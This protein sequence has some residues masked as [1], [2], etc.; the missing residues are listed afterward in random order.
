MKKIIIILLVLQGCLPY[1]DYKHLTLAKK[2]SGI[3]K[4]NLKINGIYY[5]TSTEPTNSNYGHIHMFILYQDGTYLRMNP[6]E[7][8]HYSYNKNTVILSTLAFYKNANLKNAI[9]VWGR[10]T[11][12]N[13]TIITQRFEQGP[14]WVYR[15]RE[16]I[17][18]I[19]N[20]STIVFFAYSIPANI[21]LISFAEIQ[22]EDGYK[23]TYYLYP[24]EAKPDSTNLFTM[25]KR[26]V[27]RLDKFAEKRERKENKLR[28]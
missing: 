8:D 3:D 26:I 23:H 12:K 25:N 20:D 22:K 2:D 1:K 18:R 13:D 17:G 21:G 10:Y 27:R 7:Y 11:I 9:T 4:S 16:D 5:N 15:V 24:T 19:I 28:N 6:I 14:A